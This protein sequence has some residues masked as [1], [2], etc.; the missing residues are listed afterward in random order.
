MCTA[1]FIGVL[2]SIKGTVAL[3][4]LPTIFSIRTHLG[5]PIHILKPFRFLLQLPWIFVKF[6]VWLPAASC[7]EESKKNIKVVEF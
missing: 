7:S 1:P 2:D 4:F 6:E 5:P 3:D